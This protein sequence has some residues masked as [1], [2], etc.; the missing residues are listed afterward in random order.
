[1]RRI[2][3]RTG[4]DDVVEQPPAGQLQHAAAHQG[5]RRQGVG[6]VAGAVDEE[7]VQAAAG[8]QQGGGGAGGAGAD[9]DHVVGG[10]VGVHGS[11]SVVQLPA[12]G[13]A[14]RPRPASGGRS[15]GQPASTSIETGTPLVRTS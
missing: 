14:S 7:D 8:E 4:G 13:R 11:I 15:S 10:A 2:G 1:M 5:V 12:A 9:D 6:A 3:W